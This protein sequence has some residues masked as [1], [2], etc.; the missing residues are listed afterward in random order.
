[1]VQIVNVMKAMEG[2][3]S[4]YGQLI[5]DTSPVLN[6]MQSWQIWH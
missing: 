4:R 5:K 1:M 2:N 6:A 3:L